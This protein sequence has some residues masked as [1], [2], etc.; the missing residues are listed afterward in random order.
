[1]DRPNI[2]FLQVD[3]LTAASLGANSAGANQR[4]SALAQDRI[5]QQLQKVAITAAATRQPFEADC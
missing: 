1:M 3:Q 4:I 2:L 5:L